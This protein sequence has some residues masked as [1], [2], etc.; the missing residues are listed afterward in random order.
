[1]LELGLK[2]LL[3]YLLGSVAG[4]LV[5]GQFGGFDIRAEGSGNAGATNALRTR[6]APF[7]AAVLLIDLAKGWI[8]AALVPALGWPAPDPALPREW[9]AVA[10][11]AAVVLGH[12]WPV[13]YGFRGGKGAATLLGALAGLC[14]LYVVPVL[15]VW[16]AALY[17]TGYVGLSTMLA[18]ASFPLALGLGWALGVSY[19][20]AALLP[21]LASFGVAAT[22]F[23][24]YTHRAN[25]SRMLA[26]REHRAR[27]F[28]RPGLR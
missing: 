8:G 17:L 28:V 14:A 27:R 10:C 5:L 21:A 12:V 18:A 2:S 4:A 25:I 11:A 16:L 7:A 15:V 6:G 9:L 26:G 13:W 23:T 24:A 19:P 22:L 3:A 1:M 20:R